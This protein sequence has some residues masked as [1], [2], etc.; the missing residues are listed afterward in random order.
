[1]KRII[2]LFLFVIVGLSMSAC[3]A[4]NNNTEK[5]S[6]NVDNAPMEDFYVI[7]SERYLTNYEHV[8]TIIIQAKKYYICENGYYYAISKTGIA[9][10]LYVRSSGII[11]AASVRH[12]I[13]ENEQILYNGK[14]GD[15]DLINFKG[16]RYLVNPDGVWSYLFNTAEA[17]E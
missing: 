1:M 6:I 2:A 5:T 12:P 17:K 7:M 10:Q 16:L 9:T 4:I 14:I 13:A 11:F 8:G 3:A 15:C